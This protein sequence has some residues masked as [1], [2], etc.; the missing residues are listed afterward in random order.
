[1]NFFHSFIKKTSSSIKLHP[2]ISGVIGIVVIGIGIFV[3]TRSTPTAESITVTRGSISQEVTVTGKTKPAQT[4]ALAFDRGG[5]VTRIA[6]QVGDT[7]YPGQVLAQTDA[8]ELAAQ[9]TEAEGALA[10]QQAKL[11]DLQ[12]GSRP[13]DIAIR[14]AEADK[15][16]QDLANYYGSVAD[17]I[18]DAYSKSDDAVRKQTYDMFTGGD[19][20][21]LSLGFTTNNSQAK[22]DVENQRAISSQ[23][24]TIWKNEIPSLSATTDQNTLDDTL[25][26]ALVRMNGF[27]TFISRLSDALAGQNGLSATTV[28]TYKGAITTAR[29][30]LNT[31]FSNINTL[32][33]N[34]SSQK[35]TV[36]RALSQLA[37]TKA[38]STPQAIQAQ[39]A[40]VTQAQG[41]V[42]S[43]RAQI[44][45][46]I[47][48]SPIAG[49]VTTQ[50]AKLGEIATTGSPLI[51][52]ITASNLQIESNVP[53]VDIGKITVG[54]PVDIT[55]DAFSGEH[56][57]GHVVAVDPAETIVD[58]VVN[59][60]ITVSFDQKQE[61]IK[62]GLTAN[63]RIE[64]LR[65][66]GAL[67]LPQ[68]AILENDN[69]SFVRITENGETKE[70]PVT[71]GIRST[72]GTVEI[73]SGVTEGMRVAN[74]GAKIK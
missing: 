29:T 60:K 31:A 8:S 7:V 39:A 24:L 66:E 70:V 22:S 43:V 57:S 5:R 45:K 72:N 25:A 36:A 54:N 30:S 20:T 74:I 17:T 53:E 28:S 18:N 41:N 12:K 1:M 26:K 47:I 19:E 10:S 59:Y 14:Q 3:F 50:D 68:Y 27:R 11:E 21:N 64:T 67:T 51:S 63:L 38:G 62:S 23:T 15:A 58:G 56:F 42:D 4:V 46:T 71:I 33:Q 2:Y 48:R 61:K 37:L 55:L 32:A 73:L 49:V 65:K 40:L 9:L 34:I 13:E 44:G 6:V 69:G 16:S 52:V 35:I